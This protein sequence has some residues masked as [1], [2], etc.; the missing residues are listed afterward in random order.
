VKA[1]KLGKKIGKG[2]FKVT[3]SVSSFVPKSHTPFQ[4][5]ARIDKE[6]YLHR[7]RLLKNAIGSGNVQ[8]KYSH[9]MTSELEAVFSRG[10]EETAILLESAWRHGASFDG[11]EEFHNQEAWETAF[12]ETGIDRQK[13]FSAYDNTQP[14]PW[15]F[16]DMVVE[17]DYLRKELSRSAC[18]LATPM[19]DTAKCRS[20]GV[21]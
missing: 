12:A 19:C 18:G 2:G 4:W 13:Y 9:T 21:C 8:L 17:A 3:A 10:D 7:M 16:I 15:D 1:Q 11:W 20:C 5:E 6:T 14:M